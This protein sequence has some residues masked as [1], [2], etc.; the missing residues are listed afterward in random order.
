MLRG[1]GNDST[2]VGYQIAFAWY[3]SRDYTNLYHGGSPID[4]GVPIIPGGCDYAKWN[5]RYVLTK[6]EH[7]RYANWQP[8]FN[9][10]SKPADGY[11]Y[12][13][14]DKQTYSGGQN[15]DPALHGPLTQQELAEWE[16]RI[17]GEFR[18]P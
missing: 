18:E 15:E 8:R 6:G 14:L 5:E 2:N 12:F 4:G 11:H 13:V 1:C 3:D 9:I 16:R 7:W 10:P 17:P